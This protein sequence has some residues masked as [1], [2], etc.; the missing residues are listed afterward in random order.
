MKR[1][2]NEYGKPILFALLIAIVTSMMRP[3]LV[4][5]FHV[6]DHCP[7]SYII[8]NKLPYILARRL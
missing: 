5:V 2:I 6:P 3:T 4:G 8:V 1:I 7:Y